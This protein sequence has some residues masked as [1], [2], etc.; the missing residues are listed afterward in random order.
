VLPN[1]S[2]FPYDRIAAVLR[3]REI[4]FVLIQEGIRFQLPG[5]EP[6]RSY[7]SGGASAI[8]AW[9]PS[10]ARYFESVG[11]PAERIHLTGS[12]RFDNLDRVEG[13]E[14]GSPRTLLLITNPIDTLG[15]CTSSEKYDLV[16]R[17]VDECRTLLSEH[18]FQLTVRL[19][20]GESEQVYRD[21]LSLADTNSAVIFDSQTDLYCQIR[22]SL[23]VV[24][25]ASTVGLEALLL[26]V[27][28]GVI[29]IP[30]RGFVFDYVSSG[31]ACGLTWSRPMAPQIGRL[32]T[33][34]PR[35]PEEYLSRHFAVRGQSTE[36]VAR[37]ISNTINLTE[38]VER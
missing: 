13:E 32:L 18:G 12:P 19:H 25:L 22:Q 16:R 8:A 3:A 7:G 17:F 37:L 35:V 34:D 29:E 10:S 30:R 5:V 21:A 9:G 26:G 6:D 14:T 24:T 38:T 31:A 11:V 28:L 1:D 33:R 27:P 4:P 2:A 36:M 20:S 23:A 15:L